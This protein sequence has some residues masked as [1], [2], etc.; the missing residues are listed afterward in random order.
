MESKSREQVPSHNLYSFIGFIFLPPDITRDE[1]LSLCFN[2][3]QVSVIDLEFNRVVHDVRVGRLVFKELVFPTSPEK[4]GS[5]VI[6]LNL[7]I[8][9][10]YVVIDI[11]KGYSD[12]KLTELEDSYRVL[13]RGSNTFVDFHIKGGSGELD[14]I[15][16]SGENENKESN[17]SFF[18]KKRRASLKIYVQ[19]IFSL[20]TEKVLQLIGY[21]SIELKIVK[22]GED[23]ISLKIEKDK[24]LFYFDDK[25]S[26]ES[27]Q[28]GDIILKPKRRLVVG[29]KEYSVPLG[30]IVKESIEAI[31]DALA[32]STVATEAGPKPLSNVAEIVAIK[33]KTMR[34]LSKYHFT[35]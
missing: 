12:S 15:V 7:E 11:I 34:M 22:K 21:E 23:H 14:V 16:D 29:E 10:Q 20:L 4:L 24:G 35:K 28:N 30:E 26:F 27:N 18:N 31:I 3:E 9:E 8:R 6:C 19:G 32:K 33:T 17:W 2:S 25:N 5:A 1:Y 13:R